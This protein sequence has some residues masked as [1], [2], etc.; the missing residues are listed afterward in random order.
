MHASCTLV[1]R[2]ALAC[3]VLDG[4][5]G[6]APLAYSSVM[7]EKVFITVVETRPYLGRAKRFLSEEERFAVVNLVAEDPECGVVMQGTGG[8]RKVRFAQ[9]G[10][11]KSGSVRVVYFFHNLG[12]PLFLL[13]VFEKKSKS[14]LT[15]GEKNAL[16]ALTAELVKHYETEDSH[17]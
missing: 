10:R 11:G 12:M 7:A 3:A 16:K 1:P 8:V 15:Q 13:T 14:N 2:P 4:V 5:A 17:E 6:G 9:E